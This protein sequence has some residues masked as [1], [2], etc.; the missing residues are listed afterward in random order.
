MFQQRFGLR[1]LLTN[2]ILPILAKGAYVYPFINILNNQYIA[3]VLTH[4][5]TVKWS[6]PALSANSDLLIM[7]T[8]NIVYAPVPIGRTYAPRL[9]NMTWLLSPSR[10][11]SKGL[12]QRFAE[13]IGVAS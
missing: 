8:R 10:N 4:Q 9:R 5:A 13:Q 3:T 1:T 6:Y 7:D 11:P 2:I 12:E